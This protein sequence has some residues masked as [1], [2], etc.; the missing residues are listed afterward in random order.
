MPRMAFDSQN[1]KGAESGV[2]GKHYDSDRSG[3]ITVT[4]NADINAFKAN[5]YS[6]VGGMP[7]LR[8]FYVCECGWEASIRHCPKCDRDDL[9]K[10]E[11]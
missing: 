2:T 9:T 5:G 10:V 4:D 7:R 6:L 11:K 1:C 8:K 3:F